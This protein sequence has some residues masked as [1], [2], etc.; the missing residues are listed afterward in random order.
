[1]RLPTSHYARKTYQPAD[2]ITAMGACC[3][4]CAIVLAYDRFDKGYLTRV[5]RNFISADFLPPRAAVA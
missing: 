2:S 1:M 5:T 3:T 4:A